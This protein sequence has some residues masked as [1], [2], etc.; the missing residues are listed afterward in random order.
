M[1]YSINCGINKDIVFLLSSF[2]AGSKKAKFL[3]SIDAY[4]S[5]NLFDKIISLISSSVK[6]IINLLSE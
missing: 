5:F 3:F 2:I 1:L 6:E 4:C